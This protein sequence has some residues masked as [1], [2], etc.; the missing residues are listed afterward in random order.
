VALIGPS[1]SGKSTL[2]NIIGLL[3]RPTTGSYRLQGEQWP[4]RRPDA[5]C[6]APHAGLRVPVPPPA[7]GLHRAGERDPAG[8]DARRPPSRRGRAL[9]REPAGARGPGGADA[10]APRRAVGR[11]AAARGDRARAGRSS[12][13]WCWPT[14]PPATSTR[15]RP[16]RCSPAAAH[17]PPTTARLPDRHPRPAPGRA[18][19][20]GD[21]A[22]GRPPH[23][24]HR[25]RRHR[26]GS[27]A[28]RVLEA[29]ARRFGLPLEFTP[30]TGPAATTT[31][32][33]A[34]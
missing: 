27:H 4:R 9:A 26:Q 11:H 2:L 29:A 7:A 25:R 1:G 32:S 24:R 13:R 3:E 17:Q 16:T 23:C 22:G 21:R 19:R 10:Q 30:S 33:T 18:L 34:R 12:P 5:R 8:A 6:A 15:P 20:P 14:S 28:L 31:C